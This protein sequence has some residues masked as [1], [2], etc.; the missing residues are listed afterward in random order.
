MVKRVREL[1]EDVGLQAKSHPFFFVVGWFV[2]LTLYYTSKW[3]SMKA[4]LL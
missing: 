3:A 1:I 2:V 4:A